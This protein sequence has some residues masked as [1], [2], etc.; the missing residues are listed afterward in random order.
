MEEDFG[1]VQDVC[2]D[3]E[4]GN[5]T[6]IIVPGNNKMFCA[7]IEMYY[8]EKSNNTKIVTKIDKIFEKR[9]DFV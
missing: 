3:L 6:A 8:K 7:K 5:I 4:T 2:A 1:C 9:I